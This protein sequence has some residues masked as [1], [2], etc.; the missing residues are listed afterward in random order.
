MPEQNFFILN[1][2]QVLAVGFTHVNLI[3]VLLQE[4]IEEE[5]V[6]KVYFNRKVREVIAKCAKSKH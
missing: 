6:S 4:R 3:I 1:L 2:L 5:A